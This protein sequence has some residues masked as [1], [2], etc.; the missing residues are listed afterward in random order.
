MG[1][2][3]KVTIEAERLGLPATAT[4]AQIRDFVYAQRDEI[5]SLKAERD[6]WQKRA[7]ENQAAL[8]EARKIGAE[9]KKLKG[10]LIVEAARALDKID[11]DEEQFYLDLYETNPELCEKRIA[12]LRERKYLRTQES[13]SGPIGT[14]DDTDAE[15][16]LSVK[17]AQILANNPT[18]TQPQAVLEAQKDT[19]LFN[20]VTAA[21]RAKAAAKEGAR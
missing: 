13:L 5:K 1:D 12:G 18:L 6:T 19:D 16:E 3:E 9:N 17:V 2:T 14:P 15:I 10:Q 11:E 20:R 21:R 7:E 8:I 4:N